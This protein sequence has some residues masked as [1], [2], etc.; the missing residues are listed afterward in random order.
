VEIISINGEAGYIS[1][2]NHNMKH[3]EKIISFWRAC[4]RLIN[5]HGGL[6]IDGQEVQVLSGQLSNRTSEDTRFFERQTIVSASEFPAE[7]K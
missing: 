5:I 4:L 3:S 1:H 6:D 7:D 2:T